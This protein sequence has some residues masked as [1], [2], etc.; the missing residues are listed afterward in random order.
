VNTKLP[1][2]LNRYLAQVFFATRL[3]KHGAFGRDVFRDSGV[4]DSWCDNYSTP[5]S[6]YVQ[7]VESE[8]I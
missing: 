2:Q 3:D 4:V 6:P 1:A 8:Q 7:R 5:N